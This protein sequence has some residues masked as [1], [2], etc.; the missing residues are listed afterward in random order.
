MAQYTAKEVEDRARQLIPPVS[1]VNRAQPMTGDALLLGIADLIGKTLYSD[2]DAVFALIRRQVV[3][4]LLQADQLLGAYGSIL[5]LGSAGLAESPSPPSQVDL[6]AQQLEQLLSVPDERRTGLLNQ[7]DSTVLKYLHSHQLPDGTRVLGPPPARARQQASALLLQFDKRFSVLL[8]NIDLLVNALT[9]YMAVDLRKASHQRLT[10]QAQDVMERHRTTAPAEQADAILDAILLSTMLRATTVRP[11]PRTDKYAADATM[12]ATGAGGW[13]DSR[14]L[15]LTQALDPAMPVRAGDPIWFTYMDG[16]DEVT[17]VIGSVLW[18][19][20]LGV[21]FKPVLA[22][23][24]A[25][26]VGQA[27]ICSRGYVSYQ[28]VLPQLGQTAAL[29]EA[30]LRDWP[31][32]RQA[33]LVAF[34]A[35]SITAGLSFWT[36]FV[37]GLQSLVTG[38]GLFEASGVEAVDQLLDHLHAERLGAVAEAL[39]TCQFGRL[40]DIGQLLS[41]PA[42]MD[43]LMRE[44]RDGMG[45]S[46]QEVVSRSG[47]SMLQDYLRTGEE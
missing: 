38:V 7:L 23:L 42:Q 26:K 5:R 34:E 24:A 45:L 2:S 19:K 39:E 37:D 21:R 25:Q 27:R 40:N 31:A 33:T 17:G 14:L 36:D 44:V 29:G 4:V 13:E 6:I 12:E 15:T 8:A 3:R 10:Q 32:T 46:G 22:L 35:G 30:W 20:G 18:A 9:A 47:S 11:D 1:I 28:S 43:D 41:E 16:P